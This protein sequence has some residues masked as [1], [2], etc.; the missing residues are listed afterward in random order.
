MEPG[1]YPVLMVLVLLLGLCVGSFLNVYALR[2][3]ADLPVT[4]PPSHCPQCKTPIRP[5]DN[6]PVLGYLLLGGECRACR[7]TIGIQYPLIELAT[8]LLFCLAFWR[9]GLGWQTLFIWF[10]IANLVVIFI[11]DLREKLIFECN[12]LWLIPVGLLYNLLAPGSTAFTLT[13]GAATLPVPT[14]FVS[15]LAAMAVSFAFFEGMILLSRLAFDTDGFGH[16]DTHLMMGAGAF[17]GLPLTLLALLLGFVAQSVPALPMLVVGWLRNR[18]Y[19]SLVSGGIALLGGGLPLVILNLP[20]DFPLSPGLRNAICL[21]S[22]IAALGALIVFLR[23]VRRT[24]SYTYLPLGPA[25]VLGA[26]AALFW[27]ESI[28]VAYQS[29]LH[30]R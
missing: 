8:G 23:Q 24:E 15:A 13:L 10:F 14:A 11:T 12:S 21:L 6:I 3:L 1:L 5:Q 17:L 7:T 25:L 9:F 22:V 29:L 16:G 30:A 2:F 20:P 4:H 27:G 28:L 18:Q 26:L 19:V